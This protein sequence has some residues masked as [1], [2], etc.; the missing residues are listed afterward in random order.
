MTCWCA[1]DACRAWIPAVPVLLSYGLLGASGR[2]GLPGQRGQRPRPAGL[3]PYKTSAAD[4]P[5]SP[6]FAAD[7]PRPDRPLPLGVHSPWL[8]ATVVWRLF[9]KRPYS[10]R[11]LVAAGARSPS[12]CSA[13]SA[14]KAGPRTRAATSTVGDPAGSCSSPAC[15]DGLKLPRWLPCALPP[16]PHFSLGLNVS[17]FSDGRTPAQADRNHPGGDRP[18]RDRGPGSQLQPGRGSNREPVP[19]TGSRP[20]PT[21]GQRN[22]RLT[23]LRA[24]RRSGLGPAGR[25]AAGGV[26]SPPHWPASSPTTNSLSEPGSPFGEIRLFVI[27]TK[28]SRLTDWF[29]PAWGLPGSASFAGD[30]LRKALDRDPTCSSESR[31]RRADLAVV[32]GVEVDRDALWVP[33][34]SRRR[35]RLPIDPPVSY[36]SGSGLPQ[37]ELIS[38]AVSACPSLC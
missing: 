17:Q 8:L 29:S 10:D 1:R 14:S 28:K 5:R 11:V 18:G 34:S 9:A 20:T 7:P 16:G 24:R 4:P 36:R 15:F 33:I 6:V 21:C 23:G 22:A 3:F 35:W 13:V 12:G 30:Q 27:T 32:F 26:A 25:E 37:A 31:S 38:R 19:A 2:R